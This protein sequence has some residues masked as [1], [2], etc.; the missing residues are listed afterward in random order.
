MRNCAI[1]GSTKIAEIHVREFINNG[2]SDITVI[3]RDIKKSQKFSKNC[4]QNLSI[5]LNLLI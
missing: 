4:F 2:I 1:I 5:K 3:S